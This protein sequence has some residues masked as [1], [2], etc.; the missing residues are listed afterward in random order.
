MGREAVL[1]IHV[2]IPPACGGRKSKLDAG[3]LS[4]GISRVSKITPRLTSRVEPDEELPYLVVHPDEN[5]V[6]HGHKP[7]LRPGSRGAGGEQHI[8]GQAPPL[9]RAEAPPT[10]ALP[11]PCKGQRRHPAPTK[12]RGPTHSSA[13]GRGPAPPWP[14][15]H[16][17]AQV[18]LPPLWRKAGPLGHTTQSWAAAYL[19]RTVPTRGSMCP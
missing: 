6:G 5:G 13:K 19:T 2:L 14:R 15:P 1:V 4:R 9:P 7:V 18:R 3:G 11:H 12:G 10:V 8:Q 16:P 17:G